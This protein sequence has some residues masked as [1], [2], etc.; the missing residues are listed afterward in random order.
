MTDPATGL[1]RR[2]HLDRLLRAEWERTKRH[3]NDLGFMLVSVDGLPALRELQGDDAADR[4][5][6]GVSRVLENRKRVFDILGHFDADSFFFVL[7]HTSLSGA[8][9]LADRLLVMLRNREIRAGEY[10]FR[11]ALSIGVACYHPRQYPVKSHEE[12][13]HLAMDARTQA[14]L[15]GGDQ[16]ISTQ[17]PMANLRAI[18]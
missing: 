15:A 10:P 6:R 7:P 14:Q 18:P 8:R 4:V 17:S 5:L 3:V 9:E 16:L 11:I 13:I 2:N 12:L 1:Y